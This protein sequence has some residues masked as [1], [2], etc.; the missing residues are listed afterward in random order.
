[1]Q[2]S[3]SFD[4]RVIDGALGSRA[5]VSMANFLADPAVEIL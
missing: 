2:L 1:V 4:H 5:L 3:M